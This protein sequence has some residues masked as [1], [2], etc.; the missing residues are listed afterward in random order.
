MFSFFSPKIN[1]R[2]EEFRS[3]IKNIYYKYFTDSFKLL[4]LEKKLTEERLRF[5]EYF[6]RNVPNI[7]PEVNDALQKEGE[8][9]NNALAVT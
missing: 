3:Q 6:Q 2:N 7:T 5:S 4:R 1:N 8:K 9:L